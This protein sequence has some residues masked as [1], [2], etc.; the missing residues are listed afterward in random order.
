MD[1][2]TTI[3]QIIG[4]VAVTPFIFS[5]APVGF[6]VGL[7]PPGPVNISVVRVSETEYIFLRR[8][9]VPEVIVVV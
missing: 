8:I 1:T 6:F 4:S 5:I 7:V 3:R 2:E 9:G